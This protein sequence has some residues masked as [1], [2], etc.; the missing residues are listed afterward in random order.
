MAVACARA[1]VDH[2]P[3]LRVRVVPEAAWHPWAEQPRELLLLAGDEE[4][5]LSLVALSNRAYLANADFR[6]PRVDWRDLEEHSAGQL[7][8]LTGGPLAGVLT[9]LI[10]QAADPSNPLEAVALARRL[11]EMYA[12]VYVEL[13]YHGQPREKLVNR[14]LVALAQRLD[15]PLVATNAV[16]FARAR[17]SLAHAVL[18]AMAKGRRAD[19]VVRTS[20]QDGEDLPVVNVGSTPRAQAYLKTADEMHRLFGQL[21][22]ALAATGEVRNLVRFRL[23]VSQQ[24]PPEQRYGPAMLFGLAPLQDADRQRLGELV[25]RV[26][27]ERF[28]ETG[29][30]ELPSEIRERAETEVRAICAAGVPDLMLVAFDVAEFCKQHGIPLCVR[31]SAC[32]SLVAWALGL[33]P[34][35]LCPLDYQLDPQ[36]FVHESRGDLPDLDLE[37][38]SAHEPA[39]RQFLARYGTERVRRQ[40]PTGGL[41]TVGTLRLGINVSLGARQA[42]RSA[43]AA[44]GLEPVRVHSLARQVPLLSSP[45]AVE[46]VLTRSPEMGGS[47]SASSEPGRT[48][49]RV[50]GQIEG[51]PYRFGAHPSAYTISF[52]GPG[53]LSWLP[54]HWV[55]AD[56]T[57]RGRF[58]GPRQI[59]LGGRHLSDDPGGP[60]AHRAAVPPNQQSAWSPAQDEWGDNAFAPSDVSSSGGPV[61]ACA[62]DK[63]DLE[64]LAIPRLDISISAS[65]PATNDS[66]AYT[67]DTVQAAWRMIE[68]ADT[69]C[70]AQVESPGFQA[71]LRRVRDASRDRSTTSPA[72]G[73]VEHLAQ[74]LALWRPG[75]GGPESEEAYLAARF[76]GQRPAYFHRALAG[77]LDPTHGVLL[78]A[79]QVAEVGCL[80]GFE[81]AFA[82]QF[83]RALATGRRAQ[84][85][86]MEREMKKA[87][88]LRGWTDDQFNS[89]LGLLQEHAGYLYGHGHA[90]ALAL[91]VLSQACARVN[92][93]TTAA[94]FCEALNNG[95]SAHFG[96]GA[97]VEEARR[98]GVLILPPCVNRSGDRYAVQAG[99]L[100]E[101]EVHQDQR[102]GA[103]R[104]PLSAIRGFTI[105]A[106]QHIV[107]LRE[108][109]GPFTSLLDF[110]RRV[111]RDLVDRRD[112]QALIAVG[113]FGFTGLPRA[114]LALAEQVYSA[115]GD[116]LRAADRNPTGLGPF[117]DELAQ[118]VG[119]QL[120]AAE[121]P[122]EILAAEELGH[123]GFYVATSDLQGTAARVAEEFSTADIVELIGLPHNAP[124]TI[125]GI[126]TT[127]R[128]RQT[129]KGE[130][131]AWLTIT[132]PSGS[133]ECGVFPS[134]YQR[135]GQPSSLLREGAFLV[136]RGR[137]AHEETTGTKVWID[138]LVPISGAGAHMRALATAVEHLRSRA[139][140]D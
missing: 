64:S 13:A 112:V 130:E 3:G 104:V 54:A 98:W 35:E 16:R 10:E 88:Q 43:G 139:E 122:P 62:W 12:H 25:D 101:Q 6:G 50:A 89:L 129:R 73:S 84:R 76:G 110:C 121:W 31:G 52:Y 7:I 65:M 46:Q 93:A 82:D 120:D 94:F 37:V 55:S 8:C 23:P 38:S 95:G 42:V 126:V 61:L 100:G 44:L 1:G 48:I 59:A 51:L 134:A 41:P 9:P 80:L 118:L 75:A 136:A 53:V 138:Q 79:D 34:A 58:G 140:V 92:P 106:V 17:D 96:L 39:V 20:D 11:N 87:A 109:F 83:R 74:L 117:E 77:V 67:E 5:W 133:V 123:L 108:A 14:G 85:I 71:L 90:L 135:L 19:A 107:A 105:E 86:A 26:L 57:G 103:I 91:H 15:L 114:Q 49:L 131:M 115:A 69:R 137:L 81:F 22:A 60:L 128:V 99:P 78:Y 68:A 132:D 119:R 47:L 30:G 63:S 111:D 102:A 4:A 29:R 125:A 32:N 33:V 45:G 72:I 113:A 40:R 116:L 56:R 2:L 97:A 18:Q 27:P 127:L 36:L 70:I 28:G 24:T 21:P 66:G 124:V